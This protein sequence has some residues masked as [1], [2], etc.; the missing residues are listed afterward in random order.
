MVLADWLIRLER[1]DSLPRIVVRRLGSGEEHTIAFDEEAYSLGVEH[2]YEFATDTLRFGYSSMTTP[3]EVWDY[4]LDEA[5]AGP[6]QT[7]GSAERTRSIRLCD[8]GGCSRRPA[9]GETVP[10]AILFRKDT[11]LGGTA[12]GL[13]YGYGAFGIIHPRGVQHRSPVARRPRIRSMRSLMCAAAPT[14]A[15]AGIAKANLRL[16][17]NTLPTSSRRLNISSPLEALH[18]ARQDR[19]ARAARQGGMLI[20]AIA[21]ARPDLY[22]GLIAEVPFV[23]RALN[24]M[25]RRYAAAHASRNGSNG[26]IRSP[27]R[28]RS[29]PSCPTRPM[30]MCGNSPI[31]RCSP[32]PASPIRA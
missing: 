17:P 14:K 24:T 19:R 29:T 20:G 25:L 7:A 15:G 8:A 3:T 5:H 22:A 9:D 32:S 16:K 26:A 21:N 10:I 31:P 27:T 13:I 1:A 11:P 23:R 28:R 6:A 30:T 18:R 12:P 2:G 4:D